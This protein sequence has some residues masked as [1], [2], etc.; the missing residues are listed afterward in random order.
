VRAERL[1]LPHYDL[2]RVDLT[3]SLDK[4]VLDFAAR[5]AEG[6]LHGE[7]RFDARKPVPAVAVRLS[8]REFETQTLYTAAADRSGAPTPLVS[9]RTQLAASG[10][11]PREILATSQGE[12]LVTAGA[13]K[14]PME[15]S[16]GFERLA[17][18]LLLTLV[19]GRKTEDFSQ[20]QCAAA[21]FSIAN[22]VATSTDGIA[23]RFEQLDILGGGAINLSTGGILFGYRA[24]RRNW[25]S[26]SIIGLTSGLAR[27]SGTIGEPRVEL[28]PSGV[29]IQGTA[30]WATAGI[31]LLAG[32]LWRKLES[33]GDP[34]ARIAS[35]AR[36][37]SDP[38]DLLIGALP[39]R[40]PASAPAS[41]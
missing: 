32:D 37:S 25:L 21:R 2:A 14:V 22:G 34:C 7:L 33:T 30:A 17:G 28:D 20:L 18:N 10:V 16:Y 13:G 3:A 26:F 1:V 31:S 35:G 4:G 39:V 6:D 5:A 8:L 15:S 29:L 11:T 40:R 27:V 23:L 36:P 41:R 38:L 24:V 19:P 9:V 12:M